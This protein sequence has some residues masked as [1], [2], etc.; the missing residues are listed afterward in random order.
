MNPD[1]TAL[2]V[3]AEDLARRAGAGA[4]DGRRLLG[5]G[6]VAHDTKSSPTDPVTE[7][8]RA[9]E[10]LI[11]DALRSSRPD[12][13]IVGEE[14]ADV[15]GSSGLEWHI[16]P[17]DGTANFVYDLPSWCTSVAVV[18]SDGP[19]AGAVYIPLTNELFS[20]ARGRGAT[21]DGVSI[22]CSSATELSR[23]LVATGFSYTAEQRAGQARRLAFLLPDVRDVRRLGS[24][25]IDL[26]FVACGRLDAYF[27]E[28]LNSWDFAAGVLI[29]QE[30][31]AITSDLMGGRAGSVATVAAAPGIHRDLVAT[32]NAIDT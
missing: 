29:A 20:A 27:E 22:A 23:A 15:A 28:Y 4:L 16:D 1:I 11:V 25:A 18:D 6:H 31:G 3:L 12:D 26:C 2:R 10:R 19:L 8:D 9:A 14:G 13:A 5:V 32:I 17:I 21:L 7:Y 30:A 24:A